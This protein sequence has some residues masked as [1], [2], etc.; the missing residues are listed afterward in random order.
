MGIL[1]VEVEVLSE[2]RKVALQHGFL[3]ES[4]GHMPGSA[5]HQILNLVKC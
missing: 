1:I 3:G 2:E 5:G 4:A